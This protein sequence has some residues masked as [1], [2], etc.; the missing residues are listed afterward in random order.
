M[1][2]R[3]AEA[4]LED[5]VE[6]FGRQDPSGAYADG[7]WHQPASELQSE[8]G[9]MQPHDCGDLDYGEAGS[10]NLGDLVW[11]EFVPRL[12]RMAGAYVF[13]H[14][15]EDSHNGVNTQPFLVYGVTPYWIP[16][17]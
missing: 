4:F 13:L 9:R 14:D 12:R 6:C 3:Q 15:P 1:F 5:P 10:L 8:V 7:A 17:R 2:A 16:K 11:C